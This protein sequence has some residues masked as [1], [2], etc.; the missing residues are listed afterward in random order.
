MAFRYWIQDQRKPQSSNPPKAPKRQ[1]LEEL[2]SF[3]PQQSEHGEHLQ[4][5]QGLGGPAHH[6]LLL[7]LAFRHQLNA[8]TGQLV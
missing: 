4:H 2:T 8:P 7:R 1:A 3:E 5:N 6:W